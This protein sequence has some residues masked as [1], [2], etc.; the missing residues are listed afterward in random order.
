MRR[1]RLISRRINATVRMAPE[2]I[3]QARGMRWSCHCRYAGDAAHAACHEHGAGRCGQARRRPGV[4]GALRALPTAGSAPTSAGMVGD[5][6]RAE[7]IAQDVFISALRRLRETDRPIAFKPWIYEI[8][9]NACIDEF[10]RTQRAPEVPLDADEDSGGSPACSRAGTDARRR[11]SSPSSGS[12]TCAARSVVCRRAT[13]AS[14]CCASSRGSP[15]ARSAIGSGCPARRREHPVPGPAAARARSTTS[16]PAD[17]AAQRVQSL[18]ETGSAQSHKSLGIRERRQ[19]ARHLAHCQPCRRRARSPG[20]DE[21]LL[22]PRRGL[23]GSRRCCRCRCCAGGAEARAGAPSAVGIALHRV[24]EVASE[25]SPNSSIRS[26]RRGTGR[27]AGCRGARDRGR[28][29]GVRGRYRHRQSDQPRGSRLGCRAAAGAVGHEDPRAGEGGAFGRGRLV[30]VRGGRAGSRRGRTFPTA[31]R[32]RRRWGGRDRVGSCVRSLRGR[33]VRHLRLERYRRWR[34]RIGVRRGS[35]W[36]GPVALRQSRAASRT[37][38]SPYRGASRARGR[39]RA[40]TAPPPASPPAPPSGAPS[41]S[42]PGLPSDPTGAVQ[43][44]QAP[45]TG[46]VQSTVQNAPTSATQT[47]GQVQQSVPPPPSNT[48]VSQPPTD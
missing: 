39:L 31:G 26:D 38:A 15:T 12:T 24:R 3:I 40:P 47:G 7:D 8:A 4:R 10:R 48:A 14:S 22:E 16:S 21:S 41:V 17:G 36:L 23:A 2:G 25:W 42:G 28:R 33:R 1:N 5:H 6:A 46:S 18:I 37:E 32:A 27:A 9:K 29:R 34:R 45:S 19:L 11:A 13:T 35:E 30:A 20:F 43:G 44:V